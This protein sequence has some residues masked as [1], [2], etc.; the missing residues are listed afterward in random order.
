MAE[1]NAP[2][3]AARITNQTMVAADLTFR[4]PHEQVR[5]GASLK[6]RRRDFYDDALLLP[7]AEAPVAELSME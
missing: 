4:I 1:G 3:I 5:D 7:I 6:T 2:L